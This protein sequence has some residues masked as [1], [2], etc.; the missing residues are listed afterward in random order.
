GQALFFP[1]PWFW[2]LKRQVGL[3]QEYLADA[4]AAGMA[5]RVEDYAEFLVTLSRSVVRPTREL[6]AAT[7]VLGN[8][9]DLLRRITMLL[10]TDRRLEGRCP[11]R[12]SLLAA[13]GFLSLAVL[14]SGVGVVR[15]TIA[16]PRPAQDETKKDEPKKEQPKKEEPKKAQPKPG[17]EPEGFVPPNFG[18]GVD[19]QR[20]QAQ[21]LKAMEDFNKRVQQHMPGGGPLM[22]GQFMPGGN[23]NGFGVHQ[24]SGRLGVGV[25]KPSDVLVE[26]LDLPKGQGLVIDNVG[27][28]SAAAKAGIKANDILLEIGGKTVSNDVQEFRKQLGDIKANS[29]VDAVVLRKGRK[30]TV[31]GVSLP[32]AKDEPAFEGPFGLGVQ[33]PQLPAMPA[34]P[35]LPAM[36]RFRAIPQG[37]LGPQM[38]P[39]GGGKGSM[40][41]LDK[42]TFTIQKNDDELSISISGKVDEGKV[43]V[44]N[45]T[46]RDG[47]DH[48]NV[49]KVEAVPEKYR[50]QVQK[51]LKGVQAK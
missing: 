42:G 18:G 3:C 31:K 20:M 34:M 32:E 17:I 25:E 50:E 7:G 48:V 13:G 49:D 10:N 1:L 26:Q 35:N 33:V 23:F 22:L 5:G 38:N 51:L 11:R 28:E 37:P 39:L 45:V 41:T 2:W 4:A 43:T 8:S 21:M 40:L 47:N 19:P 30:E 29:P 24:S 14:L 15:E 16:A 6:A 12:W 9:S 44:N 36:P 46:I 27:A